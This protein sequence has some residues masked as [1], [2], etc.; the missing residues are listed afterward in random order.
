[1]AVGL[2][3]LLAGHPTQAQ[4]W[5]SLG[6][7]AARGP[8]GLPF[9]GRVASI[10]VD[11][12]DISH[13]L[14]GFGNGGVWETHDAGVSFAQLS[15]AWPTLS[16]GAVALAS[17]NP[18]IIYVGTG[19]PDPGAGG[20]FGQTGLGIMRST[21]G[22]KTWNL[23][24]ASI[25]ARATVK[26][27][28]VHP[29][30][31]NILLAGT[32]RGGFGRDSQEGAP[33]S[34]PF[35]VLRSTDGGSTWTRTLNGQVTALEVDA[36]N[37][38]N[39]YAAIGDQRAPNGINND[40]ADAAP[41]G[42]YRST[43]GGQ[44]WSPVAGPWGASSRTQASVGRVELAIAPS[45]PD[46]LYASIQVSPNG[47]SSATGLLG[48][49]RTNNAWDPTPSWIQVPTSPTGDGGYCGPSKCGYA[50][51]I[52]VDP[53]D[54]ETLFAGGGENGG[55]GWKCSPCGASP[56]WTNITGSNTGVHSDHHAM[57]WT[58]SRFVDGNDGGIWSTTDLGATWDNHNANVSTLMFFGGSLHPTDPSF[59]LGGLRD[60]GVVTR[61][62][63][64]FWTFTAL[65]GTV[66]GVAEL[67]EAEVAVSATSPDTDWMAA[68]I[69]G[70][71]GRTVDG[72]QSWTA[73][74]AGIDN[75]GVSFVAPVRPC[76]TNDDVFLTGSNRLWRTNNFF[77]SDVPLWAAN[78]PASSA[79]YPGSLGYPGTILEIEF[80]ASD[81]SCNTYA[82]GNRGGQIQL[83][84]DGGK[85][86]IDLDPAKSLP[87]RPVNGLALDP[88]N[89]NVVYAALSSF[90]DVTPG[91]PGHVFKT[92]NALSA[93][94]AWV[95]VSPPLNEPFNVIR[96]DPNNPRLIYAGS[97]TGLWHS[98]D[99]AATWVHDGPGSGLPNAVPIYDIKINPSTGVT[100]VFTY[101]RGAFA[102]GVPQPPAIQAIVDSWDYTAG[103]APGAWVTITGANLASG[104]P[105]TWNLSGTKLLPTTLGGVAVTFNGTSAPLYYVSSTQ[106]NAL[107][108]ASVA[109]GPVQ[110]VVRSN[111]VDS[112]PFTITATAALPS[113]YAL[114]NA[115]GSVFF[116]T[117][118]LAGTGT[119]V[120]NS[121]VDA[122][123]ARAVQPGDILDLYMIGLGVTADA[124]KFITNQVFAGAYPVSAQLTATVAG[125][126]AQVQF[127]GLTSPGLYLVRIAVPSDIPA[128]PQPIQIS[129]GGVRTRSSLV[130]MV[131]TP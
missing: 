123:V 42:V 22:G 64:N 11:P 102:M 87:P 62:M 80:V 50:H 20:G 92:A 88:T 1:V 55:G 31:P 116:V 39:Q 115:D 103:V 77:S 117:A 113:I 8:T 91:K 3:M 47:G 51:V 129:V 68:W 14:V 49:Y 5:T 23:L 7:N 60:N 19:E 24:A 70:V 71:I 110:V 94:P 53:S 114:P 52:S 109:P 15:D 81:T 69:W 131:G 43:D 41:N 28:R 46:V 128:G 127:A 95:N 99:G 36:A 122:R 96:V 89:P 12:T 4:T 30:N 67:G 32:S 119:L 118:A 83:T 16:I 63:D 9:S 59:I 121:A 75:T 90:D 78:S 125:E 84:R 76:P 120:G 44:T 58:G 26:R 66:S 82:Y 2:I 111:G 101:G 17:S 130:L 98:T 73:A 61:A 6:A 100:A 54:P 108:P 21:D 18:A 37:F 107:V 126:A 104:V 40:S 86:W 34:P 45:N 79:P 57:A 93:S 97:D 13:W 105:Q 56:A 35:G 38:N 65:P 29:A 106:I 48:L 10:A 72:G 25:F 27:I 124:S 85:T 112:P 33:S 74:N